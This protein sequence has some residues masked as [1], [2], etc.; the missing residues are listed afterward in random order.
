ME[1]ILREL[2]VESLSFQPLILL[3]ELLLFRISTHSG[4]ALAINSLMTMLVEAEGV[5]V[6][7]GVAIG[8]E[9]I[10]EMGDCAKIPRTENKKNIMRN[11]NTDYF[12]K[13]RA[14]SIFLKADF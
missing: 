10:L 11:P 4:E 12:N 13:P 5:V 14:M 6:A 1:G 9:V 3:G 8:D 7:E 2:S